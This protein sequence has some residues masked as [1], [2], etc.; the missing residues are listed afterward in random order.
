MNTERL[1]FH[2]TVFVFANDVR[3]SG[4][5][6]KF[7]LDTDIPI[8]LEIEGNHNLLI[9][10]LLNLT[11]NAVNYSRGNRCVI[12]YRGEEGDFYKFAF[13]DNG[14]G[15][16]DASLEHLF[17]R[18]YRVDQGRARKSGGTGLGLAIVYNTVAAHGGKITVTNRPDGGLEFEFTLLKWKE[19]ERGS[20]ADDNEAPD[21]NRIFPADDAKR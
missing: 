12:E 6:G 3:D 17:D 14:Q 5:L 19:K 8:G 16:P 18:F 1:D 13:Y 21:D 2:E 10:M 15:V 9:G 11:K 20:S 7:H 4:V